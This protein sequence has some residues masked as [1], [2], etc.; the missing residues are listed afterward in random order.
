MVLFG[1]MAYL[2]EIEFVAVD[3]KAH[4]SGRRLH[5]ITNS[6]LTTIQSIL[7]NNNRKSLEVR[8]AP[9]TR[10]TRL[11]WSRHFGGKK[12]TWKS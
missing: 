9:W 8:E 6:D 5:K 4:A 10:E 12:V 11:V 2:R 1:S 3:A 7:F